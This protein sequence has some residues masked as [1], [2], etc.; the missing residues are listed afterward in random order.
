MKRALV[1]GLVACNSPSSTMVPP[2]PDVEVPPDTPVAI[3]PLAVRSLGVQ[4]FALQYGDDVVLTAPM[5][6][7]QSAFLVTVNAPIDIDTAAVD[8]GLAGIPLDKVRGVVSGHAHYDHLLDVPYI[9]TKA[10]NAHVFANLS[11]QHIFAALAPDR[12]ASCTTPAPMTIA[13]DRVI[14]MDVANVDWTNCASQKP[15]RAG[16]EGT[17]VSAPGGRVR[18][19]AFCSTHPDQIGPIHFGE[20]SVDQ[21]LCELPS[22]AA[23]WLEGTTLA[24][25]IDFLDVQGKPLY[26][27]FYQ[28]APTNAPVGHVPATLLA[29]HPVD[30]ALLCV[31]SY[32][33]VDDH[34]GA[35]VANLTP[36]YA[37]SGHWEDFFQDTGQ[38][39]QPIPLLDLQGYLTA[40][41]AVVT[42]APDGP[43]LVDGQPTTSRHVLAQPG[44]KLAIPFRANQ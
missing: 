32:S 5:F 9:L 13:R 26:R 25:V 41:E 24:F 15:R 36:R 31:G 4:G 21:D 14:A 1:A 8:A 27:V 23:D 28:D 11:A 7:R 35:V 2:P 37:V 34:P 17:W 43:F 16:I 22:A 18:M 38:P 33:A 39:P 20:G 19:K 30:L 44:M 12:P 42:G 3:A 6:T 29:E 10:P 40:V